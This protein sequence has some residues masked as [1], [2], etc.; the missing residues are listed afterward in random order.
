M[1]KLSKTHLTIL[2]RSSLLKNLNDFG[3]SK[4]AHVHKDVW[5]CKFSN[6]MFKV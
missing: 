5:F 2:V 6:K 3:L 4:I 1:H